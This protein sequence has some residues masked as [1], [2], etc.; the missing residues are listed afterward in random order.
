MKQVLPRA[1]VV[2][3][4]ELGSAVSHRLARA[5]IRVVVTDLP[6][7]TC[8]RRKVCF[9]MALILGEITIEGVEGLKATDEKAAEKPAAKGRIVVMDTDFGQLAA[10]LK[11]DITID[12]RMLKTGKG[13]SRDL[14]PLVIGLGPGFVAGDNV[15][16]VIETRRGHDLGR[17]I[18]RGEAQPDTGIPGEIAGFAAERVI[19]ATRSGRF[20]S[21]R[22]LGAM[23]RRGDTVGYIEDTEV[24]A[25]LD[26]LLRGLVNDDTVVERGRKMGDVDPRGLDIDPSTISDRGRAVAGGVLE[27]VMHWWT[28]TRL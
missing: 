14:A 4:G 20:R 13:I 6:H 1:L 11:P 2:G 3:G 27:A 28:V 17:V 8:I 12:A 15:H 24:K 26:G 23:V 16:V 25:P 21:T 22:Q 18:Y 7:P 9:A 19:R 10:E 5:G